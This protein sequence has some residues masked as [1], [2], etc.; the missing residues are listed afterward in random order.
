[1]DGLY[2]G[3]V[4]FDNGVTRTRRGLSPGRAPVPPPD[5]DEAYLGELNAVSQAHPR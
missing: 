5:N 3:V 2:G 4:F 1:M